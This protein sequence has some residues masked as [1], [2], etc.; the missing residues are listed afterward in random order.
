VKVDATAAD[1]LIEK[2]RRFASALA[3]DERVLFG[4]L[5]APGVAQAYAEDLEVAGFGMVE[6]SPEALRDSLAMAMR[7]RGITV[8]GFDPPAPSGPLP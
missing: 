6:W 1:R 7:R 4:L 3:A 5:L 2:M 8:A